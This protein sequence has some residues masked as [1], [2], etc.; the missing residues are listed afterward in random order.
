MLLDTS[1]TGMGMVPSHAPYA[2]EMSNGGNAPIMIVDKQQALE[3]AQV[4]ERPI[5]VLDLLA[6]TC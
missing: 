6:K 2:P 4:R 1:G 5:H 3:A